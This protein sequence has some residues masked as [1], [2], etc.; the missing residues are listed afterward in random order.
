[1]K[2]VARFSLKLL[3]VILQAALIVW[4]LC[5]PLAWLL[6]DGLG[7]DSRESGWTMGLY[8]FA[9]EWVIPALALAVSLLGLVWLDR[10]KEVGTSR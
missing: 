2:R 6:R 5:I 3:I 8:R 10:R 4:A 1:M 9:V 7:P